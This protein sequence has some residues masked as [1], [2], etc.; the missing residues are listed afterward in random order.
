MSIPK[1]IKEHIALGFYGAGANVITVGQG[2]MFSSVADAIAYIADQPEGSA[3]DYT[4]TLAW[5]NKSDVMTGTGTNFYAAGVRAG[6]LIT[7]ASDT[8]LVA[9]FAGNPTS[10]TYPILSVE[11]D[12]LVLECGVIGQTQAGQ[13]PTIFRPTCYTI[14]LAPGE[15]EIATNDVDIPE[16][17][18]ISII[19]YGAA[20][21][22]SGYALRQPFGGLLTIARLAARNGVLTGGATNNPLSA[23]S[24][25]CISLRA[26]DLDVLNG[27]ILGGE[28][29]FQNVSAA[30]FRANNLHLDG[31]KDHGLQVTSDLYEVKNVT[32]RQYSEWE[33][34]F[35][36]QSNYRYF[37]TKEKNIVGL[38]SYRVGDRS[39]SATQPGNLKA[40]SSNM[41]ASVAEVWNISNSIIID[42]GLN[43]ANFNNVVLA[44]PALGAGT[45]TLN[46]S[47]CVVESTGVHGA[48]FNVTGTGTTCN[49]R[50]T[51]QRD[52][53]AC[54]TSGTATFNVS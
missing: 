16:N 37:G 40:T 53:T 48:H 33:N 6:D 42:K 25:S 28:Q 8:R 50:N 30:G 23:F 26:Y 35:L 10:H 1:H 38:V 39:G 18:N 43:H 32:I 13:T 2:A 24:E 44:G 14:L 19:G 34:I 20:S 54:T 46:F 7:L 27:S 51:T 49:L 52:G 4:G 45:A 17:C 3:I 41:G 47:N 9:P 31:L 22:L 15:H 29:L 21:V 5:T 12:E 11:N 36:H